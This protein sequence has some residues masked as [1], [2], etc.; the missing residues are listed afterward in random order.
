MLAIM[1]GHI[2]GPGES[3]VFLYQ[4][5]VPIFFILGG[6]LLDDRTSIGLFVQRKAKR[7]LVPFLITAMFVIVVAWALNMRFEVEFDTNFII[8]T[9]YGS[10]TLKNLNPSNDCYI[11][12]LW[13]LE[14]MFVALIEV[15]LCL[16]LGR[17]CPFLI[18]LLLVGA[19]WSAGY[20]WLPFNI[21]SGLFGGGFLYFGYLLAKKGSLEKPI[22]PLIV[23]ALCG[24]SIAALHSAIYPIASM[25]SSGKYGLGYLIALTTSILVILSCRVIERYCPL[26]K[27]MLAFVGRYS[28]Y[29]MC[30]HAF[31]IDIC[32]DALMVRS[33][34]LTGWIECFLAQVFCCVLLCYI[35]VSF[36]ER[37][38]AQ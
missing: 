7:L 20:I 19:D 31:L 17:L 10:G 36:K 16:K 29:F 26:C 32:F 15:R 12:A 38:A 23:L 18:V 3:V 14:A 22:H 24:L 27:K 2:H 9:L 33:G 34:I 21:Q 6:Y 13:F 37:K 8:G 30:L 35:I 4:F 5:H 28:L 1:Y 11:G 25:A